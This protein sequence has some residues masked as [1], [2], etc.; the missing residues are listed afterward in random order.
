MRNKIEC[1]EQAYKNDTLNELDMNRT[2][3]KAYLNSMEA[4]NEV[5]DFSDVIWDTDIDSILGEC[6]KYGIHEMTISSTFSGL[7][8]TIAKLEEKGC[9]LEGLVKVKSPYDD[10][11]TGEKRIVPAFKISL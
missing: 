9:K 2:F 8:E 10:Y 6:K 3:M 1:I 4:G 7:I 11:I 5:P